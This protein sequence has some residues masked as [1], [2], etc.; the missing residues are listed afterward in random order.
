MAPHGGAGSRQGRSDKGL[1]CGN[2]GRAE[3]RPNG[4]PKRPHLDQQRREIR[5]AYFAP[6]TPSQLAGRVSGCPPIRCAP[7]PMRSPEAFARDPRMVWESISRMGDRER[8]LVAT[9]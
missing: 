3:A 5:E 9:P 1:H 6:H 7:H 2:R 8:V 4:A